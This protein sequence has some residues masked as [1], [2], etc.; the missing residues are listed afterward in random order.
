MRSQKIYRLN[1][2]IKSEDNSRA[3]K[4]M[5]YEYYTHH[6]R[7]CD[8]PMSRYEASYHGYG[9]DEWRSSRSWK[10]YRKTQYKKGSY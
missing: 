3:Y 1:E 2:K 10:S 4:I 9:Y 5:N 7:C 6:C 8:S